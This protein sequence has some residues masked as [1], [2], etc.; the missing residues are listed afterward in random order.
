M[1]LLTVYAVKRASKTR[2]EFWLVVLEERVDTN[3]KVELNEEENDANFSDLKAEEH[4]DE[5]K[6][7]ADN[8][9]EDIANEVR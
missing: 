5:S 6:G 4:S 1:R 3:G 2:R 9:K 7:K 8:Q